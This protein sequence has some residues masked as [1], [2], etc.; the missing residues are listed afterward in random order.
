MF[1]AIMDRYTMILFI[2]GVDK[3][4]YL[5]QYLELRKMTAG[6]EPDWVYHFELDK[7]LMVCIQNN[8]KYYDY[9]RYLDHMGMIKID[10]VAA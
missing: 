2:K 9:I 4:E 1:Q 7:T 8:Q 5:D 6:F 3:K 10:Y